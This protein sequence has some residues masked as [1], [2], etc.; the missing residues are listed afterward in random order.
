MQTCRWCG[1][2]HSDW[3]SCHTA[4]AMMEP[5]VPY[6]SGG[7]E[8]MQ[9]LVAELATVHIDVQD[10]GKIESSFDRSAH[11]KAWHAKRREQKKKK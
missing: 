2:E 8:T 5:T 10:S 4:E 7:A 1:K 6:T 9:A 3:L 11:M